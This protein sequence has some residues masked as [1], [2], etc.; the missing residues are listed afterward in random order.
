MPDA[1]YTALV[2]ESV[3]GER[4]N[5]QTTE[6]ATAGEAADALVQALRERNP[7]A[8]GEALALGE[9]A[10]QERAVPA[11]E[12]AAHLRSHFLAGKSFTAQ[13]GQGSRSYALGGLW[14]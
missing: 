11:S 5:V 14:G 4:T 2:S 13:G 12:R 7:E 6:H 3:N 10:G 8:L 1:K 9:L